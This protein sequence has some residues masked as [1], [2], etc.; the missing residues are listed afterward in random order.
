VT[1][2]DDDAALVVAA[3]AGNREAWAG[4][5]HRHARR[6]AAYLGARLRRPRV[7]EKLVEEAVVTAYRHLHE[8]ADPREFAAWLRRIGANCALLWYRENPHERLSEPFPVELCGADH[9]LAARLH[10]LEEA[11]AAL[12]DAQRMAVEGSFRGGMSGNVLAE[13]LHLEPAAAQRLVEDSLVALH[14]LLG[15]VTT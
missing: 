10:R 15:D 4:L 7:V 12:S 13:S 5:V 2:A 9:D 8:L 1:G 11:L 6:L 3:Q 14:R